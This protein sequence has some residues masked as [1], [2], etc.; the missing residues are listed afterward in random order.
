MKSLSE[1]QPLSEATVQNT[2]REGIEELISKCRGLAPYK[3][4]AVVQ[5]G[6]SV[7]GVSKREAD[8]DL[9]VVFDR[10]PIGRF[11][12]FSLISPI[13]KAVSAPFVAMR[14]QGYNLFYSTILKSQDEF[15]RFSSLYLDWVECSIVHYDPQGLA[16][17][18]IEKTKE[19]IK[20]SGA[21]RVQKGLKWYWVLK[22]DATVDEEFEIGFGS[23]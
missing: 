14:E 10:L 3:L 23:L 5:F 11:D 12:R 19:W 18:V 8:I 17:E 16:K 13:E 4:V 9:M 22:P 21:F 6:S 7:S 20:K 2:I 15:C 1:K